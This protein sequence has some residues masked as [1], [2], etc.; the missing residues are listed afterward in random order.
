M[1][2][3]DLNA[4]KHLAQVEGR[5]RGLLD[6]VP[7]AMVV[8]N[9]SGEIL[10]LNL[11]AEKQFGYDRD[12]L[13]GQ[14]VKKII[15]EDFAKRLLADG[16]G[17]AASAPALHMGRGSEVIARRK[18]GSE[19]PIEL[20]LS[21]LESDE[22][23]M[24]AAALRDI[25]VRKAAEKH[26]IERRH[27]EEAL[28]VEKERAQVTLNSIGDA[29]ACTD[30]SGNITF[31]NKVAET[32]TGWS[33][34]EA[35]G[36]SM[37]EVFRIRDD[38]SGETIPD[39]MA[40]AIKYDRTVHLPPNC[41]LV[42]R[43][44][45]E[46]PIEDSVAPIHNRDGRAS[47]AVIVLRDVSAGR[48]LT[49]QLTHSA[50]HDFLTG[51]P[52][53]LLLNDRISQAIAMA[54][55]HKKKVAVMFL[56][57]DGFKHIN[58]SLGHQ[59]GD[60]VLQSVAKLLLECMR[61]SDTLSRQGGDEFITL[62]PDLEHRE[63]AAITA[64]KLLQATTNALSIDQHRLRITASIGVSLYPEDGLDASTLIKN[65]D[66]AMYQAKKNGRQKYQFFKPEMA[67]RAEERQSVEED[68]RRALADNETT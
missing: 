39:P 18:D 10:L 46:I 54:A 29:V 48:A 50:Q 23:I 40:M 52:N 31:L 38:S 28:F 4:E 62:L 44:G 43:D 53:R 51:L 64:E 26:L 63:N 45:A 15:R 6:A 41:T 61:E 24:F 37:T 60:K 5:Y 33:L 30:I 56:D 42:R 49:R 22:G 19:F 55:R 68:L 14:D 27:M 25:S 34:Q 35:A 59:I 2:A 36:R 47:G 3:N 7:D 67:V 8:L 21:E 13:V 20:M 65:A 66:I 12:E 1:S 17:S 32:M 9:Q 16:P 57:L 11:Q 58:D